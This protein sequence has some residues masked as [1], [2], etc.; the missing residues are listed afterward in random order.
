[1]NTSSIGRFTR[2]CLAVQGF[3]GL[4]ES[5]LAELK[6]PLRIGPAVCSSLMILGLAF[7]S[8]AIL[9][10]LAA[11]GWLSAAFARGNPVDWVYNTVLRRLFG[12]APLPPNPPQRRFSCGIAGT[13]AAATA[14]AFATGLPTLA[15]IL[16]GFMVLASFTA[17]TTHLCLGG[18]IYNQ[19]FGKTEPT[20]A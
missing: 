3:G 7:N 17:A 12:G 8:L 13:F 1:M 5:Q 9:V 16:G 14:L 15:Y 4:N 2:S 10:A 18:W 6:G 20:V 11:I 19:L